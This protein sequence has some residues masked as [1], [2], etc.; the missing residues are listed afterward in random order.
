MDRRATVAHLDDVAAV[1]REQLAPQRRLGGR[2]V[3]GRRAGRLC[4]ARAHDLEPDPGGPPDLTG[5]SLAGRLLFDS[6]PVRTATGTSGSR[7]STTVELDLTGRG[8]GGSEADRPPKAPDDR[9]SAVEI[10]GV[11]YTAIL[12]P[13]DGRKNLLDLLRAFCFALR[14]QPEAT[15]LLKCVHSKT[16]R[17][18][19]LLVDEIRRLRPLRCRVVAVDGFLSNEEYGRLARRSTFVV[20]A[21]TGEGQCLP[22]MELMSCGVPAIAPPHTGMRDYVSADNALLVESSLEPTAWPHDPRKL[23]RTFRH[24]IH[25]ETLIEGFRESFRVATDDVERY[26]TMSLA[27]RSSL[28]RHCSAET[29]RRRLAAFFSDFES[30]L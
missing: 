14:D 3:R 19:R 1:A 15:L 13:H 10:D 4:V 24:R 16:R 6:R 20:N 9:E 11:L 17:I 28:E 22:L 2:R 8:G 23:Y 21:S 7:A 12:N 27:A 26:R 5:L 18:R 25:V 30:S 29:A